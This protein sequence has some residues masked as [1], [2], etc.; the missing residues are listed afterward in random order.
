MGGRIVVQRD[1]QSSSVLAMNSPVS[2]LLER[3]R[4]GDQNAFNDLVSTLYAELHRIAGHYI[5][6]ERSNH[7]LQAT[8]LVHEAYMKL[9]DQDQP[10]IAD[11]VHFLAIAS[12]VMRQVLVDHARARSAKKRRPDMNVSG[13]IE[14]QG[15][16]S[17]E[18]LQ[19]LELDNALNALASEDKSL[20]ELVEMRYFGGMTAEESAAVL[21]RSVHAVRHDLRLAL[22]WLRRELSR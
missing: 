22:A 14:I 1:H 19:L 5:R 9:L 11:R 13:D 18:K 21:G 17:L 3:V 12:R 20:A 15:P 7:T 4:S 16:R 6:M 8:A 10:P 2:R